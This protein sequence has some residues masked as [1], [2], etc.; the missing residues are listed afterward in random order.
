MRSDNAKLLFK[1][2][3]VNVAGY[4]IFLEKYQKA[5]SEKDSI[6]C[7]G[8][9]PLPKS[10]ADDIGERYYIPNEFFK[11]STIEEGVFSFCLKIIDDVKDYCSAIKPN[12]QHLLFTLSKDKIK[13]INKIIHSEGLISI[14]D[15]KLGDI[16]S[17]NLS[18]LYWIKELGFDALTF[19]PF[20]GNIEHTVQAAHNRDL[21]LIVLT[22][23]SNPESIMIQKNANYQNMPIFKQIATEIKLSNADGCVIGSTGHITSN[24]IKNVRGIVGEDRLFLCPGVGSQGG[25]ASNIIKYGGK[26]VLINV[27]RSIIYSSNPKQ[28]TNKFNKIFNN[29]RKN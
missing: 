29:I 8:L 22:L 2:F 12:T 24:D 1:Y 6:L 23:M 18:A 11:G 15:H 9:D 26:N 20:A 5:K 7:V 21:G 17:T 19:S 4:M 27:G 25:D 10:V 14:L 16:G 13:E 28:E 3:S